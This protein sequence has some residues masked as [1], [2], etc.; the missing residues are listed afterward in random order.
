MLC[1]TGL[2]L[3]FQKNNSLIYSFK[4]DSRILEENGED[5]VAKCSGL[6]EM[7]T[8]SQIVKLELFCLWK[9]LQKIIMLFAFSM[10]K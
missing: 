2:K 5:T 6:C 9:F 3:F 10:E 7:K 4:N 1:E 8:N